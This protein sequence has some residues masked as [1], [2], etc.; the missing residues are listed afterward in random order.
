MDDSD[1]DLRTYLNDHLSG[2][3][4]GLELASRAR[5]NSTDPERTAMWRELCGELEEE[6]EVLK[7]MLDELD[8]SQN[9]VKLLL[10]W[11]AE[12]AG[13][14]KPNGQLT[15]PS[16][17]GQLIELEG[18]Y[19]GVTGK[20]SMWTNLAAAGDPRLAN[21]DLDELVVR[22]ESQRVR[23]DEQRIKL[24]AEIFGRSGPVASGGKTPA[25]LR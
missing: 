14:L 10:G 17:L 19:V 12:K 25:D 24:A 7:A 4:G 8:F 21:F 3:T 2:S 23:I 18:I 9:P 22:A 11:A 1:Q 6:R 5:H 16:Q 15:G 13:R 20:L